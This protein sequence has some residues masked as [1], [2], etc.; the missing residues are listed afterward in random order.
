MLFDISKNI[1]NGVKIISKFSGIKFLIAIILK[2]KLENY[3]LIFFL[4]MFI[5]VHS[6]LHYSVNNKALL[7]FI[8][9]DLLPISKKVVE[10]L[11]DEDLVEKSFYY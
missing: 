11:F 9:S 5:E 10:L 8:I 4:S 1:L 7:V 2:K 6:W 3:L